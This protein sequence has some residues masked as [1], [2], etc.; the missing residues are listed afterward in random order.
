MFGKH[1][2]TNYEKSLPF[3]MC[4]HEHMVH[5]NMQFSAA[6]TKSTLFCNVVWDKVMPVKMNRILI[7]MLK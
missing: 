4:C 3:D 2:T 7:L 5:V 6:F 1:T